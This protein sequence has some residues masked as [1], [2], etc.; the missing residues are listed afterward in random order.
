VKGPN[1]LQ[2]KCA[3]HPSVFAK[4]A[5][6]FAVISLGGGCVLETTYQNIRG[7]FK[8]PPQLA[9]HP[10]FEIVHQYNVT[11]MLSQENITK[12]VL[13]FFGFIIF[14]TC[15]FFVLFS[16]KV[17]QFVDNMFDSVDTTSNN[18][19]CQNIERPEVGESQEEEGQSG[20]ANQN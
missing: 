10:Y 20:L 18:D 15:V 4:I 7:Q 8:S 19:I 3:N 2:A 6:D 11:T 16:V 12:Y 14:A 17:R 1:H 5:S 13:L 9:S